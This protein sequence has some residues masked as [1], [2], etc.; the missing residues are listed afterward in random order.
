MYAE[1]Q[2]IQPSDEISCAR[3]SRQTGV[4]HLDHPHVSEMV[5]LIKPDP[6]QLN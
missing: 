2:N 1:R 3:I 4:S 5:H 6:E